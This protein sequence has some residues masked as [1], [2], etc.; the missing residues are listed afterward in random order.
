LDILNPE[1]TV[2]VKYDIWPNYLLELKKRNLKA[3]LISALFRKNQSYFKWYGGMMRKSLSAFEHIFVQ[4]QDSF[5]LL[6]SIDFKS[7]TV[8]GDTRFDRV[9][10]QLQQ[11]NQLAFIEEFKGDNLC[12]VVGSSWPE[13]EVLL[14]QFING[15]IS[16]GVKFIIAPHNV[17]SN[18]INDLVAKLKVKTVLFSEKEGKNLEEYSVFII[19]TIGLLSKMY[20]YADIAYVGGAM[21]TTG[22]HN[23]LEPAVFG[24]PIIIGK[25]HEKFPEAQRMIEEAGVISIS[26]YDEL[27][28]TLS[29]FIEKSSK[30]LG[31]GQLNERFIASNQGAVVRIVD[32]L[33]I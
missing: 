24:V 1:L 29:G 2:F 25:N 3:I 33:R 23:I 12:V 30:R 13:D 6:K 9:S 31:L 15:N 14:I 20:S 7:V 17:K 18:Q 4:N 27:K 22:L 16:K 21:G 19:N 10:Q 26:S 28:A 5:E 11:D 32:Y 8:A